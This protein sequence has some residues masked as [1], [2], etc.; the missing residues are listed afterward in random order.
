MH[1]FFFHGHFFVQERIGSGSHQAWK[2]GRK[3]YICTI[4]KVEDGEKCLPYGEKCLPLQ[5]GSRGV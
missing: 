2:G 4:L 5:A 3:D 1:A